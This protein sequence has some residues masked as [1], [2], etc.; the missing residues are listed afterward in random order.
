MIGPVSRRLLPPLL[1]LALA[2][3]LALA[4]PP[5]AGAAPGDALR[6][7]PDGAMIAG[8]RVTVQ[9]DP[10]A[11]RYLLWLDLWPVV[12]VNAAESYTFAGVPAGEHQLRV[13]AVQ[14]DASSFDPPVFQVVRFSTAGG[15]APLMPVSGG[16]PALPGA[17][18]AL[19]AT[20]GGGRW[21]SGTSCA[22]APAVPARAPSAPG[23]PAPGYPAPGVAPDVPPAGAPPAPPAARDLMYSTR[24]FRFSGWEI[25]GRLRLYRGEHG[26]GGVAVDHLGVGVEDR[27]PDEGLVGQDHGAVAQAHGVVVDVLHRG[28]ERRRPVDA[29][30]GLAAELLEQHRPAGRQRRDRR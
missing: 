14:A 22:R 17:V 18:S 28:A 25:T 30:A 24:G 15:T 10:D 7:P 23:A 3:G 11:P 1:A 12:A 16:G 20:L 8:D 4:P 26:V 9:L 6:A 5:G 29:V 2:A 13:E 19:L 27:L 21:P